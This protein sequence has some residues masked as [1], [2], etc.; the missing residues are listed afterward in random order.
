MLKIEQMKESSVLAAAEL[1]QEN[2]S[3]PWS[4]Q[5]FLDEIES[6][7][8]LYLTAFDDDKLI[9]ICGMIISCDEADVMNISVRKSYRRQ[10]VA[11]RMLDELL[12]LGRKRGVKAFTL[13]VRKSNEAAIR[14][15]EKKGF[16]FEGFRPGFY[17][18]PTEDAAIYWLRDE[19]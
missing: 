6:E 13:E 19:I 3:E 18:K 2:F 9:G 10:G 4:A 12:L 11:D 8:A 14:L 1:E 16:V 17:R 7:N 15:Y 5:A